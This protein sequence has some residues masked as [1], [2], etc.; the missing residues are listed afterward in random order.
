MAISK[1]SGRQ[2]PLVATVTFVGGTDVTA[3]ASYPAI[4]I[5]AGSTVTGGYVEVTSAFDATLDINVGDGD[6]ANLYASAVNGAAAGRT[7]LTLTGKSY[8]AND[9]IGVGIAVVAA[10]AG[11][12]K[13]VV[14]YVTTDRSNEDF[15]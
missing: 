5:P 9:T 3:V 15:G 6:T 14:E 4:D 12:G 2:Y 13:L 8:A 7:A 11:A 1:D 10:T